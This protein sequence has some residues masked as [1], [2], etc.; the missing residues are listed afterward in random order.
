MV[1]PIASVNSGPTSRHCSKSFAM[2]I[3]FGGDA[4]GSGGAPLVAAHVRDQLQ[5]VIVGMPALHRLDVP[6]ELLAELINKNNGTIWVYP[7]LSRRPL[8]S[9]PSPSQREG[10]VPS[11]VSIV[12]E[13]CNRDPPRHAALYR[14][15]RRESFASPELRRCSCPVITVPSLWRRFWQR[16]K[17]S[18]V[19][20]FRES[21]VKPYGWG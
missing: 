16:P 14:V 3:V 8:H 9:N 19:P 17:H 20:V 12:P 18:P 1:S 10:R 6:A 13:N 5:I 15:C 21:S 7:S 11:R 2:R 4:F